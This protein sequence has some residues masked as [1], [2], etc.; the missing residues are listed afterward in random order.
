MPTN[1]APSGQNGDSTAA[2]TPS[3]VAGAIAGTTSRFAGTATRLTVPDSPAITG[4]QA[5]CAAAG[6]ASASAAPGGTP[7]RRSPSRHRGASS[8]RPDVASTDRVNPA[9][10][11]S[12]GS[13][14][15]S[16]I[17]P[18]AS[19][20]SAA[21]GR[22]AASASRPMA[23]IAAA[24]TTLGDGR[25]RMTNPTS[26]TAHTRAVTTGP[27]PGPPHREEHHPEHDRHV[28]AAHRVEVGHP[29]GTEVLLQRRVE[30]AGVTD[31]QAR[32]QP[33]GIIGQRLAGPLQPGPQ[34]SGRA[35]RPRGTPVQ[36][37]RL[38]HRQDRGPQ[39]TAARRH[40][41]PA[42]RGGLTGKQRPPA[43]VAGQHQGPHGNPHRR[44]RILGTHARQINRDQVRP[45][46][47]HR[48][49]ERPW[50]VPDDQVGLD[51]RALGDQRGE[52]AGVPD[53]HP[54]RGGEPAARHTE[55]HRRRR[56]PHR[57]RQ[58]PGS[59]RGT[60]D[61]SSS[62]HPGAVSAGRERAAGHAA[63]RAATAA[64][65]T[66]A[67]RTWPTPPGDSGTEQARRRPEGDAGPGRAV[68]AA[69]AASQAA[70]AN[71]ASR[72]SGN[73]SPAAATATPRDG[74][75]PPLT[76]SPGL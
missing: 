7:R 75:A 33:A 12:S 66:T 38:R 20:G 41:P 37:G 10:P 61:A 73:G 27:G 54:G 50:I 2:P 24:R 36:R 29:G 46:P 71:P 8:S 42:G 1:S 40:Q 53:G 44:H 52:R 3:S 60:G 76:P 39:I 30:P 28:G 5:S 57:I 13:T 16:T 34:H 19:A 47:P 48:A 59:G 49:P 65:G 9:S 4:P 35:L 31:D 68:Q 70:T 18:A 25:A 11:A 32:Q 21:R 55:Q 56:P 23:P 51:G 58:P 17:T 45:R 64:P 22:P 43:G 6:T 63:R 15:I 62:G 74:A 26:A 72:R 69:R 14:T 67:G